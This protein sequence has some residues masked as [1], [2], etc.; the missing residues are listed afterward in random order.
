MRLIVREFVDQKM[1]EKEFDACLSLV[2][3][4]YTLEKLT[5]I[6]NIKVLKDSRVEG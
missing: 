1:T 5:K 4:A 2:L 6:L 3:R